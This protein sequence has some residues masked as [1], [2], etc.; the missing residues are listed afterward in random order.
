MIIISNIHHIATFFYFVFLFPMQ[1]YCQSVVAGKVT[2]MET[3]SALEGINVTL[4][5]PNSVKLIAFTFTE[6]DG[7]YRLSY[8]EKADSLE[9]TV[10]GFNIKS[11]TKTVAPNT[12]VLDFT[13]NNAT[14]SIREVKVRADP[15]VR[16]R[17]TLTY[18]VE[19][20]RTPTDRSIGD[21]LK[22]LPGIQVAEDGQIKYNGKS[23]N[24]FYIEGLDMMGGKYGIA[25]ANVQAQD[26][27]AVEIYE[28]HQPIRMLED[29]IESDRAALNLRLKEK[30][31]GSWNVVIGLGLG[32]KPV[33]WDFALIPMYFSRE[34]QSILTFK[35]NNTG[36]DVSK[37]LKSYGGS[38]SAGSRMTSVSGPSAPPL[39]DLYYLDNNIQ[40]CSANAVVKTGAYSDIRAQVHYTHDTQQRESSTNTVYYI[41]G[42]NPMVVSEKGQSELGKN[43]ARADIQYRLNKKEIYC[44]NEVAI[45]FESPLDLADSYYNN[46]QMTEK[47]KMRRVA[48][49][50]DVAAMKRWGSFYVNL[51]SYNSIN[52]GNEQFNVTPDLFN[53]NGDGFEAE[54]I[55]ATNNMMTDNTLGA[56][57][58]HG[59]LY[60]GAKV[61]LYY[62]RETITSKLTEVDS[63]KNDRINNNIVLKF[64]PS[65]TYRPSSSFTAALS[66]P[67]SRDYIITENRVYL[68][69]N[70]LP[71]TLFNPTLRIRWE[72]SYSFKL[73]LNST[74]LDYLS[75]PEFLHDG[76][77]MTNYRSLISNGNDVSRIKGHFQDIDISY[78]DASNALFFSV[79]GTYMA[80]KSDISFG[81]VFK[82]GLSN[83]L[84]YDVPSERESYSFEVS[85][86]KRFGSISTLVKLTDGWTKN[87]AD[88]ILQE[89]QIPF[90]SDSGYFTLQVESRPYNFFLINY[91]CKYAN[92][93]TILLDYE[94]PSIKSLRQDLKTDFFI[95]G[96]T[97]VRLGLHH[98]WNNIIN[99]EVW[100]TF[101]I[102]T[103]FSY[104]KGELEYSLEGTNL[105]NNKW[106]G[107]SSYSSNYAYSYLYRLRP[108]SLLLKVR[109]SLR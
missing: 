57:Y 11:Q 4:H 98:Y 29:W 64:L 100:K 62:S 22:K 99:E 20:F 15:L 39:E 43:E 63:M 81:T 96:K 17:D 102:N 55:V 26:I 95:G 47:S 42:Q 83:V 2:E 108:F 12:A 59:N 97:I 93:Q 51:Y 48:L 74:Y 70:R 6:S 41:P 92:N 1:L 37:E 49:A 88:C 101:F 44:R 28:N 68:S 10:S 38:L 76:Y 73:V 21:V 18:Y 5:K 16:K 78:A 45:Q 23:I 33:L 56:E 87:S 32:Y 90:I 105:L 34:F 31:K 69:K 91:M 107:E 35:A 80:T 61:N 66:V 85:A 50:D 84:T 24:V 40:A 13:V 75:K 9:L 7:C 86:S 46:K 3:G 19:Q 65:I 72:P 54:Q 27:A 60:F 89:K 77:I 53:L 14:Q 30:S 104:K 52:S 8:N 106:Y 67:V 71:N 25:T 58:E 109:F 94:N 79:K 82:G 36:E 103:S